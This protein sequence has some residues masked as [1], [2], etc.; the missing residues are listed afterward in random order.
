MTN[1]ELKDRFLIGYEFIASN[2]A[3]GYN[4]LEI[5]GFLNQGMDLLVDELYAKRDIAGLAEVLVSNPYTLALAV[6][7]SNPEEYG[8]CAY[9]TDRASDF[10]EFRWYVNSRAQIK[11]TEPFPINTEWIECEL[12]EKQIADKWTQTSINKPIIIYPK[13]IYH[14]VT[15]GFAVLIDSYSAIYGFQIA[16]IR[17]P[18][19]I[20]IVNSPAVEPELHKRLHQKIVDK[21]VQLAMKATDAQR[22]Q[23]DVQITQAI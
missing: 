17:T 21:A 23:A 3:P 11:R 18:T 1:S 9:W 12:I 19:R 16:F 10:A 22:A 15:N 6:S 13:V 8:N 14:G 4:D 2:L 5:A 7:G 20:D